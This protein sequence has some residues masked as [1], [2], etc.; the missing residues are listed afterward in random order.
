MTGL[1]SRLRYYASSLVTLAAGV[2]NPLAVLLALATGRKPFLL[3]LANGLRFLV[4]GPLDVWIVKETCLDGEYDAWAPVPGACSVVFDVGAGLGDFAVHAARRWPEARV[5]SF[6]PHP[7]TFSLLERN[8]ALDGVTQVV[9]VRAALTGAGTAEAVL[10]EGHSASER[11]TATGSGPGIAVPSTTLGRAFETHRIERC[12]FLKI[13]IEG[14]EFDV[15]LSAD[16]A[17]LGRVEA[18]CLEWHEGPGRT[19]EALA[20]HLSACGFAVRLRR[21][22]VHAH[23][24]LLDARRAAEL[25]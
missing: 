15:L 5:F 6:E 1:A 23:L 14:A 21:S 18:L 13:D 7:E 8:L 10:R 16:E 9:A 22:P 3:E 20:S 19:I 24:G 17:T 25:P 4:R 12:G 11:S 2:R